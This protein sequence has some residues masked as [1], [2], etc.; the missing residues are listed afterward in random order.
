MKVSLKIF[1][2]LTMK[3]VDRHFVER[4]FFFF[5]SSRW[6]KERWLRYFGGF[7]NVMFL[8]SFHDASSQ[9]SGLTCG[10]AFAG[11]SHLI[12]EGKQSDNLNSFTNTPYSLTKFRMKIM[13]TLS[14]G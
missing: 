9:H 1:K 11:Y 8:L 13:I 4:Y 3:L 6:G 2:C 14:T 5:Q 10:V 12:I 7:L